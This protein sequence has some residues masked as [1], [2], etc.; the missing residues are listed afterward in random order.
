MLLCTPWRRRGS[1]GTALLILNLGTVWRSAVS[2]TPRP[3]YS[4]GNSPGNHRLGGWVGSRAVLDA[5]EKRHVS[6]PCREPEHS[7]S[8]ARFAPTTVQQHFHQKLSLSLWRFA[9]GT[10]DKILS[11]FLFFP[12]LAICD[13]GDNL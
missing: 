9:G 8:D 10:S 6:Y 11:E 7:F 12:V 13:V 3:L 1:G 4:W 2:F 5:L